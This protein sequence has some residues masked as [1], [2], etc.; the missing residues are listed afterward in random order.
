[1]TFAN[2]FVRF[3][4]APCSTSN[5]SSSSIS[6]SSSVSDC[7]GSDSGTITRGSSAL[8]LSRIFP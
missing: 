7:S 4:F 5:S 8:L 1:V 6:T 3:D 2:F